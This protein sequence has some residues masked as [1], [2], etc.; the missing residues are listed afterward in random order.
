MR[1]FLVPSMGGGGRDRGIGRVERIDCPTLAM[2]RDNLDDGFR[3]RVRVRRLG[4]SRD[5]VRRSWDYSWAVT[6]V[7]V[8][9]VLL[10]VDCQ[11]NSGD[12]HACRLCFHH[13]C[14]YLCRNKRGVVLEG[15]S[16]SCDQDSG[17]AYIRLLRAS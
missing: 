17:R 6:L 13:L 9:V 4:S 12:T 14:V 16:D 2:T 10:V 11:G 3:V 8:V 1:V 15:R 7:V 5:I